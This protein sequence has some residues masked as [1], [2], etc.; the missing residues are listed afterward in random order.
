MVIFVSDEKAAQRMDV[1]Q[2][3]DK[4][5]SLGICGECGCVMAFKVTV[6]TAACPK[7]KWGVEV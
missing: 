2:Q 5:S 6:K 1:C 4:L 7:S 3:C